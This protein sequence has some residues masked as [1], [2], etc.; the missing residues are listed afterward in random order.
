[1][2]CLLIDIADV[3]GTPDI[4]PKLLLQGSLSPGARLAI[5]G[6]LVGARPSHVLQ[7]LRD[8]VGQ[9]Y[10]ISFSPNEQVAAPITHMH[11][12][13]DHSCHGTKTMTTRQEMHHGQQ[14]TCMQAQCM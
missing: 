5:P 2:P 9:P 8:T 10:F 14:G 3:D 6:I 1:M 11:G 7:I 12:A 13:V 4:A